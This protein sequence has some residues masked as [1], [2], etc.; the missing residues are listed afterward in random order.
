[1]KRHFVLAFGVLAS[2]TVFPACSSD[3]DDHGAVV[4]EHFIMNCY[5]Q[6]TASLP[7]DYTVA[8]NA[9][10]LDASGNRSELTRIGAGS[11][12]K[13]IYGTWQLPETQSTGDSYFT[14]K[15]QLRQTSTLRIEAGRIIATTNCSSNRHTMSASVTSA[16]T[17]T[18]TTLEVLED[19][20]E[21]KSWSS[22]FG[23]STLTKNSIDPLAVQPQHTDV[24]EVSAGVVF[25]FAAY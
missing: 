24:H 14:E 7:L 25:P 21:V 17:I 11:G 16:A 10:R 13:A 2:L 8:G 5:A 4:E 22:R 23:E 6:T 9:L 20:K 12:D 15:Y 18:D 19:H 3:D 1:M